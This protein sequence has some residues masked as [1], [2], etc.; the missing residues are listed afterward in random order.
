MFALLC[1][2]VYDGNVRFI[3]FFLPFIVLTSIVLKADYSSALSLLL[4]YPAPKEPHRPVTFV[5]DALY[6]R[7]NSSEES[8][9]TLIAKYSGKPPI[10]NHSTKPRRTPLHTPRGSED[11]RTRSPLRSPGQILQESGGIEG[12]LQEAAKGVYRRSEQ[13][14]LG[15][16]FRNA[17]QGLQSGAS[18][19]RMSF[20][21]G[22]GSVDEGRVDGSALS[23]RIQALENRNKSLAKMLQEAMEELS[24][25]AADFEKEKQETVANKLT[26]S[27]AKLQFLH[28]YLENSTLP[29]S[30]DHGG[31]Q[32][33][34]NAVNADKTSTPVNSQSPIPMATNIPSNQAQHRPSRS[35]AERK[36]P[37]HAPARKPANISTVPKITASSHGSPNTPLTSPFHQPRPSLA[38]SSFSWMLGNEDNKT[39]FSSPA[40][41]S[42][43]RDKKSNVRG[44]TG[45]LFGDEKEDSPFSKGKDKSKLDKEDDDGFTL[46]TLRGIGNAEDR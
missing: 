31:G 4:R 46:G 32:G 2:F 9:A 33:N 29:L 7:R 41:F 23:A 13:W 36:S 24:E 8:G 27:I 6:L 26:L 22:K 39:N 35:G 11:F 30:A 34:D 14:G 45:F 17:V 37:V 5:E 25:Q 44:K 19:P 15:Q 43:E 12:L 38:Q 40:P 3:Q 18:T 1:F 28:V 16:A 10:V 21:N 20:N 42:P